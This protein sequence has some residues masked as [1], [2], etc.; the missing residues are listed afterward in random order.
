MLVTAAIVVALSLASFF[1]MSFLKEKLAYLTEKSTPFQMRTI[2]LQRELQG[3]ISTLLEIN[4][5]RNMIEYS[6]L[7]AEAEK[8]LAKVSATQQ[9]LEKH[10][11]SSPG[12]TAELGKLMQELFS[13]AE[14]R[15]KS[16]NVAAAVNAKVAE[17]MLVSSSRLKE[18]DTSIRNLQTARSVAFT[19]SLESTAKTS[20]RLQSV[21][22]L[23]DLFKE[24]QHLM[25]NLQNAQ[26]SASLLLVKGKLNTLVARIAKNE[27]FKS[28]Q[29]LSA[30]CTEVTDRFQE[31]LKVLA[32]AQSRKDEEAGNRVV[33]TLKELTAKLG[34]LLLM[35]DQET[36]LA[37]DQ[38]EAE[39]VR[40]REIFSQSN[41]ANSILVANSELM[42]SG[43]RLTAEINRLF[44]LESQTALDT[45][46][47]EIRNLFNQIQERSQSIEK[48]LGS[49]KAAN[50]QKLLRAA[51]A[52]F[53]I[54]RSEVI[55]ADGILA[56]LR[57]KL[58]AAEQ[59]DQIDAKLH[60][61]VLK[62]AAKGSEIVTT[63]KGEQEQAVVSV[64]NMIGRS[65]Y[66]VAGIGSAAVVI[67]ILFGFWIYRSVLLPLRVVL[68][69]VRSQQARGQEKAQLAE[70]VARGDLNQEVT[71]SEILALDAH[72]LKKDEM[73]MVLSAVVGMSESQTMLDRA[74]ADMTSSLR[75]GRDDELLRDRMKSGLHELNKIMREEHD[76]QELAE[77]SLAF[78]AA[79]LDAGVGIIYLYNDREKLL[80]PAATY[81]VSLAERPDNGFLKPGE[82]LVGQVAIERKTIHL[83]T[84]PPGYL[85]ISS[86]LGEADPLQI[87]ILP[88]MHNNLLAGVLEL[89]SFKRFGADDFE[90]LEQALE[91]MA[92]AI[93]ANHSRQLVNDLLEQTQ[94]QSEEL[95]IQQEQLQQTNE[96]LEER[97]RMFE[98]RV[99][100]V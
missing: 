75:S 43:L 55:S 88:I 74:L 99:K 48:A 49:M 15:I 30:Q 18:L 66:Q 59:A 44:T 27:H 56:A 50:E 92:I 25:Q 93:N 4:A 1:S 63:A 81:A 98:E 90:F 95:R 89:G 68:G 39:I 17:R 76:V 58:K 7:K 24:L 79:F 14:A 6:Q 38:H 69:A 86:A 82:G 35:L 41:S 77:Y 71:I 28:N 51:A 83:E 73:G 20:A 70:A 8:K 40:Q 62:Q 96:E 65:M 32:G 97:A 2:E 84:V 31:Q 3:A 12:L 22:V 80:Q 37:S 60:E 19:Q 54:T 21:E 33:E 16:S 94:S 78:M 45:C 9:A 23:R 85:P 87:A 5:A 67:G 11:S 26:K 47:K 13:A 34:M 52:A 91:G 10:H 61:M 36:V 64:N 72:Q 53:V 100:S 57:M 42:A 46:D 29:V